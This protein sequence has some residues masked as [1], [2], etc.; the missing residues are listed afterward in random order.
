MAD[1]P[2]FRITPGA[3]FK[4]CSVDYFGPLILRFSRRQRTKGYGALYTCLTP[5]AIHV[6]LATD[7][8]IGRFFMALRRF[9]SLYRQPKFICSDNEYVSHFAEPDSVWMDI[10][11]K[12]YDLLEV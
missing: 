12:L 9:I 3:P 2:D 5:R 10:C 4:N 7:L 6:E 8:S 1:L 11:V